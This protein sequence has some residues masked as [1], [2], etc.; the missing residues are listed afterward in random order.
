M[1]VAAD[2][3]EQV[4]ARHELEKVTDTLKLSMEA[5][6]LGTWR[7]D[8]GSDNLIVSDIARKIHGIP[9]GTELSYKETL[10]VVVPEHRQRFAQAVETALANKGRFS[11]DY[12]VQPFDGSKRKWLNSTGKVEL[13][14]N[15]EVTG[16]IGTILDITESKEDDLRKNDFIGMVSHELKTP[17]TSLSG[18]AQ[19]LN[20]NA[21]RKSDDFVKDKSDRI[22]TQ[23]RK[24]TTMINGF[25]N[26]S[27]L[28]SGKIA[29]QKRDFDLNDLIKEIVEETEM[30]SG[31]HDII[32]EPTDTISL[33]ADRDKIG[34]VLSNLFSNAVK[35]SP[36]GK[37]IS[38][39]AIVDNDDVTVSVHD[40]GMGIKA[41]DLEK[42]FD[43]YYRVDNKDTQHIAGFGIGL[44]LC[45]E[46]IERH[47]G[48]I[49][50]DSV[51]GNGSTF[52]FSLPLSVFR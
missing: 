34:T 14:A 49:W 11:E 5:A 12:Q 1:A 42:L 9:L 43:R 16:V 25:L 38:I 30:T 50:A 23:V 2:V 32:F 44:Y 24:M 28:E 6:N 8:K 21:G 19:M 22:R 46:I 3:T 13:D 29:L 31:S 47:E 7:M 39:R 15:G 17:L 35:Y 52:Y 41:H 40:E 26:V 18:Y 27:R 10:S 37:R 36:K 20:L 51:P 4:D 48:K 33:N 45:A